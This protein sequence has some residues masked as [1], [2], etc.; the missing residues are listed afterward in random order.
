ME[1]ELREIIAK[2]AEITNVDFSLDADLREELDVDS[3]RA[4][5]LVFEIERTFNVS[6]P[7]ARVPELRTLRSSMDLLTSLKASA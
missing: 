2:V 4:I 7:P 3:H 6:I 5:E 1:K